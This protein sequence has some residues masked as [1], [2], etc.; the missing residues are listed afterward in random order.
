MVLV[1]PSQPWSG[2]IQWKNSRN[3][4]RISVE[5]HTVLGSM[6]GSHV[7]PLH[8]AWDP[9]P[10]TWS[11]L[12]VQTQHCHGWWS[13]E[14]VLL[15]MYPQ[16]KSSL[17]LLHNT[18]L[19]HLTSSHHTGASSSPIITERVSTVQYDILR[20]RDYIHITFITVYCYT[21]SILLL[22]FISYCAWFVN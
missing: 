14:M 2:H 6:M 20:E 8:P 19:V 21:F 3:K 18:Y 15:L 22:L 13:K 4:Q 5:L 1:I 11:A 10:L 16:V 7:I 17:M 9:R 12:D